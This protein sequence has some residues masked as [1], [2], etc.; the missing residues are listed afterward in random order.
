ME[1]PVPGSSVQHR[2]PQAGEV[3]WYGTQRESMRLTPLLLALAVS[4]CAVRIPNGS[5]VDD[6][7]LTLLKN[8]RPLACFQHVARVPDGVD[9]VYARTGYLH[10]IFTPSGAVVTGDYC[11]SHRH[12]HGVFSAWTRTRFQ[13]REVDFWNVADRQG[14]VQLTAFRVAE[15]HADFDASLAHVDTRAPGAPR[16]A[17]EESW[18]VRAHALGDA[19]V[20]DLESRQSA[21][22]SP[23]EVLEY[24]YG[25]FAVRGPEAWEGPSGARALT[26]EGHGRVNGNGRP[27]RWV[28]L[29]GPTSGGGQATIAVL[30]CPNNPRAPEPV[31]IH[32]SVPYFC[33][34]ACIQGAFTIEPGAPRATRYRLVAMDGSPDAGRLE[35][36]WQEFTTRYVSPD[37][38]P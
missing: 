12:Q 34:A 30:A 2:T 6:Y 19:T 9:A 35:E 13:G 36:L 23:L 29:S 8:G 21:P 37:S 7:A 18:R 28:A 33:F 31:R 20:I 5:R 3:T 24:H 17:L 16:V 38:R 27:A 14:A 4:S 26:S 10:P 25:G 32:P 1:E 22:K 11:A 15:G